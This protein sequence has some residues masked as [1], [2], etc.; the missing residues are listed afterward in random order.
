MT[1]TISAV[2]REEIGNI[3]P[4][5]S[6]MLDKAVKRGR[7]RF[8]IVD[9]LTALLEGKQSLWIAFD[10]DK[11]ILAAL[12]LSINQYT[13]GMLVA[14]IEYMGGQQRDEWIKELWDMCARYSREQGCKML[15]TTTRPGIGKYLSSWG[16]RQ[17]AVV[18]ELDLTKDQ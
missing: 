3:W 17:S 1:A 8:H 13:D 16:V 5:V 7:G 6:P 12:T 10:K 4:I 18:Y 11:T 2:P 14:R 15:E 9:V